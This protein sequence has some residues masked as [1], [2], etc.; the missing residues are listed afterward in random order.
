MY[1][2]V[3]FVVEGVG[4]G[5]GREGREGRAGA[6]IVWRECIRVRAGTEWSR[7]RRREKRGC[8]VHFA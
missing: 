4:I 1:G 5:G 6:M 3:G 7:K 2:L 8:R